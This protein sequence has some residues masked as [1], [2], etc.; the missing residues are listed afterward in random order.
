MLPVLRDASFL[1]R[2][3]GA[4]RR[5][6][7]AGLF[8]FYAPLD[9]QMVRYVPEG[10][11][12]SLR[13]SLQELDEAAW[14]NLD[15]T[16]ADPIAMTLTPEGLRLGA[17]PAGLWALAKGDGHDAARLLSPAQQ[18]RLTPRAG[19]SALA[20]VPRLA[21]AGAAGARGQP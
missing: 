11:L 12:Q 21:R 15:A 6:G 17:R 19:A 16:L 9:P 10:A 7:P 3:V 1:D 2:A 14:K 8:V 13:V 20:G 4:A 18:Q 5:E